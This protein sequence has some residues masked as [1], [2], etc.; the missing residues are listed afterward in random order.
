VDPKI[1]KRLADASAIVVLATLAMTWLNVAGFGSL[2][3]DGFTGYDL[4][5]KGFP[6]LIAT[7]ISALICLGI[8]I[9]SEV[10]PEEYKRERKKYVTIRIWSVVIGVAPVL[11]F[12]I[13]MVIYD[14]I[15][16]GGLL[17]ALVPL[18]LGQG[19]WL[20]L[21]AFIVLGAEIY[22]ERKTSQPS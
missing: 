3:S 10:N 12:I 20:N 17:G 13:S 1:S 15:K 9:Y 19:A 22:I 16:H 6:L 7:P 2:V 4:I 18:E 5:T 14:P 11:Y 21:I 8:L